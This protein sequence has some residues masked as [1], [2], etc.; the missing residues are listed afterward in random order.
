MEN[1]SLAVFSHPRLG[2]SL[3]KFEPGSVCEVAKTSSG[4]DFPKFP[5]LLGSVGAI[6]A[7]ILGI[8]GKFE[9]GDGLA[10]PVFYNVWGNSSLAVFSQ[11]VHVPTAMINSL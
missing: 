7:E 10:F 1:S 4:S 3:G 5:K 8:V 6:V 9:P 2:L 11:P